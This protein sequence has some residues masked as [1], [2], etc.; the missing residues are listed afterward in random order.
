MFSDDAQQPD[1]GRVELLEL[2][3]SGPLAPASP[4]AGVPHRGACLISFVLPVEETLA[5]LGDL[6][7]GGAPRRVPGPGGPS[8][9]VVDPDGVLVELLSRV[10]SL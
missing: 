2:G 6:G 7:L 3:G 1:L 4:A 5:R 10:P 9:V 8:A